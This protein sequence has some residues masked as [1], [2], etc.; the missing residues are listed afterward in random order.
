MKQ[1]ISVTILTKNSEETLKK[2]LDSLKD[3]IEVLVLD[4]G[5][6]DK[7]ESICAEFSN[8]KF[9]KHPFQGF[10]P[11]HNVASSLALHDWI[12]SIDSDEILSDGLQTEIQAVELEE[13]TIY[14]IRRHNFFNKKRIVTCA[15][16]DPD[17][18][19]RLYNRK[20]TLFSNDAVHEKVLQSGCT[21]RNLTHPIYHT[22]YRRISDL[23][24][25]MQSYSSLFAEQSREKKSS[26]LLKAL[27]HGYLAFFKSYFLKGGFSQGK[28]GFII[29]LYN[30]HSTYYKY[31]KLDEINKTYL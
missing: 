17:W 26:S 1:P 9:I 23:L 21:V 19:V 28:E 8:V 22:P 27:L 12:L 10:G 13:N 6:A 4:T 2:T 29:S 16:W 20:K 3:F 7:T 11:T 14:S 31:L 18:V 25:K 15:G 5:S 24:G 30:S